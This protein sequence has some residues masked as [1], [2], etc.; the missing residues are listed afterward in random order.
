M[1]KAI[2]YLISSLSVILLGIA[3]FDGVKDKPI[4]LAC[5]IVGLASSIG[6]MLMRWLSFLRDEKPSQWAATTSL[7]AWLNRSAKPV[8]ARD[9]E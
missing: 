8:P 3:A 2:G 1:F 6:G 5:L 9:R 7:R 4:L